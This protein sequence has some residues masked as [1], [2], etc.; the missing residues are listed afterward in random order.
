MKS[1]LWYECSSD[2][3]RYKEDM[4]ALR[5]RIYG[6][7]NETFFDSFYMGNPSGEPMLGLCFDGEKLV[8]QENYI[9]QDVGSVGIIHRGAMG[10]NTLVDPDYRLF[11]GVFGK[12][13]ELTIKALKPQVD[14]LF[15]FANEE[16]KKYYLKYF[17]WKVAT[18][19][20]VYKKI[21]KFSGLNLE[22]LLSFAKPGKR[23]RDLTL[24]QV[25]KFNPV[26]LDPLLERYLRESRDFYFYKT[27]VFLNW[28]FLNN[29]HYKVKGYYIK[30]KDKICGYCATYDDGFERKIVD[31]LVEK[32]D[33]TTFDKT[34]SFLSY[35]SRLDG[36]RRLVMYATPNCWY[37]ENL[38][39]HFFIQRWDFDFITHTFDK[40]LSSSDWV[41]HIG[42]FDIF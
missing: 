28:K 3:S 10:I 30:Y 15:A 41:I 42:D 12:L 40:T 39:K 18:K 16:S 33:V 38:R 35:Y 14:I 29:K 27:S 13:C 24:E 19:I 22:S 1:K 37:E 34:I 25:S 17:Q 2:Y 11:H 20:R 32:N 4:L 6:N 23:Q 31:L 21:T 26:L 8:G 9:R 36:M 7:E 5:K